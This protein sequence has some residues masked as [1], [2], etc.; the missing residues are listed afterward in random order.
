M[1]LRITEQV[2][3]I[4]NQCALPWPTTNFLHQIRTTGGRRENEIKLERVNGTFD[5]TFLMNCI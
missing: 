4:S 1:L 3:P 2:I 5:C